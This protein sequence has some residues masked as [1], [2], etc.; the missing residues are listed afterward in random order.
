MRKKLLTTL[1]LALFIPAFLGLGVMAV[2]AASQVYTNRG[3]ITAIEPAY[4]T[5]VVEVPKDGQRMTVGGPLVEGAELKKDGRSV[6]LSDFHTG[7]TVTVRWRYTEKGHR[8][9]GLHAP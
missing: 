6:Q 1:A 8:I 5:V 9:I 2:H 3:E 7:E 4:D